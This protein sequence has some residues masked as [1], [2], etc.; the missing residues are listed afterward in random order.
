MAAKKEEDHTQIYMLSNQTARSTIAIIDALV[1]RG[2]FRGEELMPIAQLRQSCQ[3]ITQ[4]VE[5]RE[6][7][8]ASAD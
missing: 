3:D 5:M 2:A 8:Q 6:A 4:I 1:Q 7:D